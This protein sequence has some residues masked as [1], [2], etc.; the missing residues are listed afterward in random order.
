MSGPAYNSRATM[1]SF[2]IDGEG[3]FEMACPHLSS[4]SSSSKEQYEQ[5]SSSQQKSSRRY[6]RVSG[7]LR[8]G[9]VFIVPAGHPVSLVASQS[10]NLQVVC[11]EVNAKGNIRYPLAGR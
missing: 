3:Y 9:T 1:I 6:Q 4:G 8:R 10:N 7:Q 2:V 5:G 11:F